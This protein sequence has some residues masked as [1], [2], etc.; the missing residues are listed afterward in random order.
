MPLVDNPRSR[1][2]AWVKG[3]AAPLDE[4]IN[5]LLEALGRLTGVAE[6]DVLDAVE[7]FRRTAERRKDNGASSSGD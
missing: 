5:L 1:Y 4:D 2:L 3:V 7:K 6:S